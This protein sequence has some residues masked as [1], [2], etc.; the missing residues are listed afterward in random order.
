MQRRLVA[1][2]SSYAAA[3]TT[4]A[5]HRAISRVQRTGRWWWPRLHDD[6][7]ASPHHHAAAWWLLRSA[8]GTR[9]RS[10]SLLRSSRPALR[11]LAAATR[12]PLLLLTTTWHPLLP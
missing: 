9:A 8:S 4:P 10:C 12:A 11:Q 5:S 2:C 1:R 7:D 6:G 3:D